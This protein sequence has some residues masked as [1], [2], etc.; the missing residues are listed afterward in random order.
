V[1][2]AR[3]PVASGVLAVKSAGRL[4]IASAPPAGE[5]AMGP[6][7]ARSGVSSLRPQS[8]PPTPSRSNDD[9]CSVCLEAY[10]KGDELVVITPSGQRVGTSMK[11]I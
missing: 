7:T 3:S 10:A 1:A 2:A 6:D 4:A 11:A 5:A 9:P 8:A